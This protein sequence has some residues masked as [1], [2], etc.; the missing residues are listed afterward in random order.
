MKRS[1]LAATMA[2][3][4]TLGTAAA[5]FVPS[6]TMYQRGARNGQGNGSANQGQRPQ[7]GSGKGAKAG[8]RG[9][10]QQPCDGSRRG[11]RR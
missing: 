7:D 5:Q 8:K 11:A 4:F 9:G 6:G 2:A 1:I 3:F 10:G